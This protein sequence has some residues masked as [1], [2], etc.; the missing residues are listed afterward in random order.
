MQPTLETTFTDD[1]T[2][3]KFT[4]NFVSQIDNVLFDKINLH[5]E[6]MFKYLI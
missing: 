6:N 4:N 2:A 5:N 1:S 3:V